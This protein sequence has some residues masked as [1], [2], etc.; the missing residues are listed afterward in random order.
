MKFIKSTMFAAAAAWALLCAGSAHAL[1]VT[2][3]SGEITS[4]DASQSDRITRNGVAST[5]VSP[6]AFPGLN[7]SGP[8]NYDLVSVVFAF[9]MT[10]NVF[11]EVSYERLTV[12][13]FGPHLSGYLNSF[14][15]GNLSQGYL[16]D[17]GSS[18]E[19]GTPRTMQVQVTAGNSLVLHFGGVNANDGR[20]QY[21]V[22]AFSDTNRGENFGSTPGG[23]VPEPTSLAL[24]G[25]AL[26]GLGA[27]RRRAAV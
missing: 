18:S 2:S 27:S 22:R 16:G 26:A 5:W 20:Y 25:L 10:Q 8:W 3:G 15:S 19:L 23:N 11:Y 12:G 4:G 24:V 21:S 9:N 6:K 1:L 17:T 13:D 7:G 14:N